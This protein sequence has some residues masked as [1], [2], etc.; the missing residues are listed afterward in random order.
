MNRSLTLFAALTLSACVSTPEPCD[1]S[2]DNDVDQDGYFA[3]D[4]CADD[5]INVY[6]GAFELCDGIDN[7]CDGEIDEIYG[8]ADGDGILDCNDEEICDGLDNDGDT[9]I[10]EGYEDADG[11]GIA[12]CVDEDC[13]LELTD[14]GE[15]AIDTTCVGEFD[16]ITDPWK[17]A[18][19]WSWT[20]SSANP[21]V[22]DVVNSP[23]VGQLTDDNGDGVI[24][25]LDTPDVVIP[26]FHGGESGFDV[27]IFVLSGDDGSE[28]YVFS[29]PNGFLWSSGLLILDVDNDGTPNIVA[30]AHGSG[31][32]LGK[33]LVAYEPDGTETWR[34][35]DPILGFATDSSSEQIWQ[36]FAAD[37]DG[38]DEPEVMIETQVV[39]GMTGEEEFQ[40]SP[41]WQA[42]YQ[43]TTAADLDNDGTME[44]IYGAGVFDGT[45]GAELWTGAYQDDYMVWTGIIQADTDAGAELLTFIPPAY[46][47]YDDD[48]TILFKGKI[49]GDGGS[50]PCIADFDGDGEAEIG[51]Y[52]SVDG[53]LHAFEVDGTLL[54]NRTMQDASDGLAT[55]SAFDLNNDGAYEVL[56]ADQLSVQV[57]DGTTGNLLVSNSDHC[58]ATGIEYPTIADVDNDGHAELITINQQGFGDITAGCIYEEAGIVVHGHDGDGWAP[59]GQNWGVYDFRPGNHGDLNEVLHAPTPWNIHNQQHARPV[60]LQSLTDLQVTVTDQ[61]LTGCEDTNSLKLAVQISNTGLVDASD[62]ELVVF[63]IDG[64]SRT[65]LER[66]PIGAVPSGKQLSTTE[67]SVSKMDIG[68][69]GLSV[70]IESTGGA[71]EEC[72]TD[73]NAFSLAPVCE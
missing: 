3:P 39:D 56:Y 15:V 34:S 1:P 16:E 24:N 11:D 26:A 29:D 57:M 52:S 70:Q 50:P 54:W 55:C 14:S 28:Q 12:D 5:N 44:I 58:S 68:P 27:S 25:Q 65:E 67:V 48:G 4:D 18:E 33:Y 73:N 21:E 22:R 45:T 10:D 71:V 41:T 37:L 2:G 40:L 17:I 53:A 20:G 69:D 62:V 47:L 60:K 9:Y 46:Q 64:T 7:D 63:A 66:I 30:V 23:L 72:N 36:I 38:D 43:R 35:T 32:D 49:P 8:D 61:C 42:Q 31:K 13:T 6:P 59:T 51:I 19:E